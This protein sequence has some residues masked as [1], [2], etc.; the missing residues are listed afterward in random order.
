MNRHAAPAA[1]LS[2]ASPAAR[3]AVAA[4]RASKIREVANAAL[5][6]ADVLPFWFGESDQPTPAFIGA[7][8]QTAIAEGRTFYT[9][10]MG[11]A[12]LRAALAEYATRLHGATDVENIAVTSGGVSAIMLAAQLLLGPG[13][14]LVAV[15]PVWPNLIE[16]PT[17]LGAA[18]ETVPL[19]YGAQGWTL[20]LA[21]LL[22]ALT[23][24]TRVLLVNSP[25][26]P[27][28][29]VMPRE[30]QQIVLDHCRR[31][32]IWILADE[33]YERLYYG[34]GAGGGAQGGDVAPSF[35]DLAARDERVIAVNSFSK[36]WRMTGWR[37]GWAVAPA[38]VMQDW[39]KLAEYNTCCAPDFV[40]RA[41]L[42]AVRDG[43]AVAQALRAELHARRDHLAH[44][45]AQ[46]PGIDVQAAA[47]AMYLF[48]RIAGH[49]DSLALCQALVRDAGLGLAPGAAF[50]DEGEGF[51]RWCY[52]S[53]ASR[54]DE[55]VRRLARFLESHPGAVGV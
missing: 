5:G 38:A 23:P 55:G 25:N 42:V 7:A 11:N 20:D 18:V 51:V 12:P 15:T 32:G 52:A 48:F 8:A 33:V 50:G 46:L 16:I 41:G 43:E 19:D 26:N 40:Q 9:H 1:P 28:G 35:L 17:L 53:D 30:Q 4:L 47:G 39:G 29:W 34:A 24:A 31:H 36:A 49:T 44:S 22:A 54:L 45:L 13:D 10:N 6:R 37:L 2:L 3:V 21:R 14:R 27:T